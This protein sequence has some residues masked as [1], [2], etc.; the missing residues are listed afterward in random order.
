MEKY[1]KPIQFA[2]LKKNEV[3]SGGA[4]Y[5]FPVMENNA[6]SFEPQIVFPNRSL[7][8]DPYSGYMK[9]ETVKLV[10]FCKAIIY[11]T[12]F[13]VFISLLYLAC[14]DTFLAIFIPIVLFELIG[15]CS[16]KAMNYCWT[17]V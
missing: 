13:K 6:A 17:I 4:T 14:V 16:N 2:D 11:F 7:P 8:A 15:Y 12:L 9:L 3:S 5:E 10:I 1:E